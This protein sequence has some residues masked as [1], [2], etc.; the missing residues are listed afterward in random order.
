MAAR[1]GDY[2]SFA[3]MD[4]NFSC[5]SESHQTHAT[6]AKAKFEGHGS[7]QFHSTLEKFLQRSR[8]AV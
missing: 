4:N 8:G 3:R 7:N 6:F 1:Y 5:I 2:D